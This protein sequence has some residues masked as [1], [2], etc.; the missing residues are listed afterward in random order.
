MK[1]SLTAATLTGVGLFSVAAGAQESAVLEEVVVT[2][3]KRELTLQDVPVAVSVTS[4]ETLKE[5]RILDVIELQSVVPSLRV[6]QLQT[7]TQTNFIIRGFGNGANNPGIESSVGLF[8][9]GVYRS[10]SASAIGDFMDVERVEVLRGPQSTLFGQNA[11]AGV[12]SVTTRKPQFTTS[13]SVEVGFGDLNQKLARGYLTGPITEKVAYSISAGLNQRDGYFN[14][15]ADGSEINDRDRTDFRLQLLANVSDSLSVRVLGDYSSID[16]LCCGVVNL[17]NGPTGALVQALGGRVYTGNPFDDSAY[18]NK[19]PRNEVDNQ[20]LSLHIDWKGDAWS[21]TSITAMRQQ[22][23]FFD[24]DTDFTSADLVPTNIN[25]QEIDTLTQELRLSFDNGGALTGLLGAYYLQEEVKYRSDIRFGPAFRGYATGLVAAT[26]GSPAT[27]NQLEGLLGLPAGTFFRSGT[28]SLVDT[29]QDN[30]AYTLFGQLDWKLTD[31]L[32]FT[33]GVAFTNS[34]KDVTL[35]QTNTDAFGQLDLVQLGF[36][37][38]FQAITGLPP[39]PANLANP[40]LRPAALA[41]DAISVTPCSATSPP[42]ACNTAL[43]LYPL[44][45]LFPV[46]P[47]ND[48][49]SSDSKTTYTARLAYDINDN[50]KVYGGVSTGFK[51]TSWNLSR[52]SRPFAPAGGSDRSP[53]GSRPNPYYGRYG[54]RFAGPEESTVIELGLKARWDRAALYVALFDQ[55]I[56]GFQ[57]NIFFGTGFVLGNAG[58]Q[59]TQ[60]VEIETQF[61]V[62]PSLTLELAGTFLDPKYDSFPNAQGLL[63]NGQ[64]GTVDLTGTAPAGVHETSIVAAVNYR[65]TLGSFNGALRADYR[66][67]S[68]VQVVENVPARFA[69][70]EVGTLNAAV[71]LERN[72]WELQLWARNLNDD[73]YLISA[74]PTV[75]QSGSLSGYTNQPRQIGAT[76]RKSF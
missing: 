59:S 45:F 26:G 36:G 39:T 38:A 32:T 74:F 67:D 6:S 28:G 18:F 24:Y 70:R 27:F 66:Y 43:A 8:I 60:G 2:A 50:I 20:G 40:A 76:L 9:D 51:A 46:V 54:T 69:S 22:E 15:L 30:D 21:L 63:P 33:G 56:K 16:E 37:G 10:R 58:K 1:R 68:D 64:P 72:G 57:S 25:D 41:A 4:A 17:L 65:Y 73:R 44:Q 55:E 29:T 13:G 47:F 23:A 5:A 19:N 14:N 52:D 3:T 42:P 34:D 53:L 61:A 12:I 48:G 7:S 49:N 75:A 71:S 62:T 35:T 11:S 31:R